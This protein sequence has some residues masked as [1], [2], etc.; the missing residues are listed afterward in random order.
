M[1]TDIAAGNRDR[2]ARTF[3][4]CVIGAGPAGITLARA[5]AA[6]GL[7]VA[8]MEAGGLDYSDESQAFYAGEAVGVPNFPTDESRLRFL[9]GTSGHWE[10]KC[11][12]LEAHDFEAR[13]WVP[14]SG[15]PIGKADLDPYQ[16]R[17][18]EIL[19]VAQPTE[20]PD[21]PLEQSE[22]RFRHFEWRWSAPTHFGDKYRDEL[23]PPAGSRSGST[24]TWWTCGCPTIWRR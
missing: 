14:L 22:E 20:L 18:A 2:F 16:P 15:W 10:G 6:K 9:G 21:L 23:R 1:L 24:R 11:R 17:A 5:L 3:D 19:D 7:D 12:T 13:P 8:L 4:V